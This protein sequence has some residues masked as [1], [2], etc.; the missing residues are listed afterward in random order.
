MTNKPPRF[1]IIG[2]PMPDEV[3]EDCGKV[4]ELRPYGKRK[5]NGARTWVCFDCA[6]KDPAERDRAFSERFTGENEV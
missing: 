3:C 4:E 2:E 6:A 5:A 1:V